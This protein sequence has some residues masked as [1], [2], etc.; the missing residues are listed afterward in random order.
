MTRHGLWL[1]VMLA[2][3]SLTGCAD[4]DPYLRPGQWQPVGAN[5]LNLAA[6]VQNPNDLIR[7]RGY[8]GS[9]GVE[10]TPPVTRLW[11][12][13]PAALPASSSQSGPVGPAAQAG[14]AGVGGAN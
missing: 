2:A 11:S 12:G 1:A 6:M 5:A 7:G 13:R 4:T 9:D 14:P 8:R 10:A 3:V